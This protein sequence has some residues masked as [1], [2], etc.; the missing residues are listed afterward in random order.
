MIVFLLLL[1]YHIIV[2]VFKY[3]FDLILGDTYLALAVR[4]RAFIV[5]KFLL[6]NEVDPL[7]Q[8]EDGE[9]VFDIL[10]SVYGE[11]IYYLV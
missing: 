5:A 8:N 7:I 10:R 4:K 2:F 1:Y 11:V 3:K 6:K 9:D